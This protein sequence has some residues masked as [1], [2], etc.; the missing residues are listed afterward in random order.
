M[1]KNPPKFEFILEQFPTAPPGDLWIL[2]TSGHI[3]DDAIYDHLFTNLGLGQLT[4]PGVSADKSA[5]Y[6][7]KSIEITVRAQRE[8]AHWWLC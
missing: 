4:A 3:G 5:Y 8:K 6:L 2:D 7:M 1:P